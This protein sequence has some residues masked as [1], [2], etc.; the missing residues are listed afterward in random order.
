MFPVLQII[1]SKDLADVGH[2]F[3]LVLNLRNARFEVLDSWRT[4]EDT[5]LRSCC[6]KLV[7]SIKHLWMEYYSE[8][9]VVI[10]NYETVLISVPDQINKYVQPFSLH[11]FNIFKS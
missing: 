8:S 3:L 5:T 4:L 7:E 2:Y 11:K 1:K 9:K 6:D 10:Q